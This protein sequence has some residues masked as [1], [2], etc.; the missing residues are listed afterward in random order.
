MPASVVH[1][2]RFLCKQPSRDRHLY[3]DALT[4]GKKFKNLVG[5]SDYL[6]AGIADGDF[7]LHIFT[8]DDPVRIVCCGDQCELRLGRKVQ[9]FSRADAPSVL[10]EFIKHSCA[11]T[12]LQIL[13]SSRKD[14][15]GNV[16][17][18]PYWACV[19]MQRNFYALF[20]VKNEA[21]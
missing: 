1:E 21:T 15:K 3:Y 10:C 8:T 14:G 7:F 17:K 20:S 9:R 5:L 18:T 19:D 13:V 2:N 6:S 11:N 16:Q 12:P 4:D